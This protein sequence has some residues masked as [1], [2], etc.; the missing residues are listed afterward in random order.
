MKRNFRIT[1]P[2]WIYQLFFVFL[3]LL[4]IPIY[5]TNKYAIHTGDWNDPSIWNPGGVPTISDSV[6]ISADIS[7]NFITVTIT[8]TSTIDSC[9]G[10]FV[11]LDT[12]AMQSTLKITTGS[13]LH[14]TGS[15]HIEGFLDFTG[16]QLIE[17]TGD[18]TINGGTFVKGSSGTVT[19]IGNGNQLIDP[20]DFYHCNVQSSGGSVTLN[21]PC[22]VSNQLSILQGILDLGEYTFN[23]ITTGKFSIADGATIKIGGTNSFPDFGSS[24]NNYS[25]GTNSTTIYYG[26]TGS[27]TITPRDYGNLSL[28]GTNK[29]MG[30]GSNSTIKIFGD[31]TIGVGVTLAGSNSHTYELKKKLD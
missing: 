20:T 27:Q 14:V 5:A 12:S 9:A 7:G 16:G 25:F 15:V 26:S 6:I 11:G 8:G 21:G 29:T 1:F 31:L 28:T 13:T 19:F 17:V 30:G 3:T 22:T 10:V 23:R 18:W 24:N 2:R 4:S